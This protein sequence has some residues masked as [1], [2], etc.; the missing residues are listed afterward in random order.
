MVSSKSVLTNNLATSVLMAGMTERLM[1]CADL[2]AVA[3]ELLTMVCLFKDL[4]YY[5][6][7]MV[8]AMVLFCAENTASTTSMVFG[9]VPVYRYSMCNG[10]EY[11]FNECQLPIPDADF[12]CPS[13]AAVNCTEGLIIMSLLQHCRSHD[14]MIHILPLQ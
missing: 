14:C 10:T 7:F 13:F 8:T 11:N 5:M 1:W 12:T 2:R 3:I 4:I 9:D 6:L